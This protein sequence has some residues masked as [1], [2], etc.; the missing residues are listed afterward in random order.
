MYL[1]AARNPDKLD[2][3]GTDDKNYIALPLDVTKEDQIAN[4]FSKA[5]EKF[6]QV[7]WVVI[8]ILAENM[9]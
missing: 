3:K 9:S 6:G 4:A 5:L 1:K 2:F 7:E 8:Y